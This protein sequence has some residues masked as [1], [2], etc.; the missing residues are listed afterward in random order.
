M[1]APP[2]DLVKRVFTFVSITFFIFTA[3]DSMKT[4]RTSRSFYMAPEFKGKGQHQ[5]HTRSRYTYRYG[6]KTSIVGADPSLR[7]DLQPL[8]TFRKRNDLSALAMNQSRVM[9]HHISPSCK[10]DVSATREFTRLNLCC[11]LLHS[12]RTLHNVRKPKT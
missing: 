1:R 12:K 6:V 8:F 9:P 4:C 3:F 7:N 2:M 5:A 10:R 11:Q